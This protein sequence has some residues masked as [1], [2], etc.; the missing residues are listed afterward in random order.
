M[1]MLGPGRRGIVSA[2]AA[3]LG[4]TVTAHPT[5]AQEHGT[6]LDF[7]SSAE[8]AV[9]PEA[10]IPFSGTTLPSSVD[11]SADL[12]TPG[13]QGAQNSCVG[14]AVAYALKTFLERREEKWS[15]ANAGQPDFT[16]LFSPAY[17]YNQINGGQDRGSHFR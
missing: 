17:I 12:P 13:D 14:W 10:S 15:L 8:L 7:S 5:R 11:L 9:V 2:V 1:S 4:L 16:H 3:V 6:G